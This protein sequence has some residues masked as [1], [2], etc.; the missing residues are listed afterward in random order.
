MRQV[1]TLN[2]P[3]QYVASACTLYA[4]IM[5][6]HMPE[7]GGSFTF[8]YFD[9][10]IVNS[11]SS[12]PHD[13]TDKSR[14]ACDSLSVP[15][16][17]DMS[18]FVC[19]LVRACVCVYMCWNRKGSSWQTADANITRVRKQAHVVVEGGGWTKRVEDRRESGWSR[20]EGSKSVRKRLI[21]G[22]LK[23]RKSW[24]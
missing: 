8:S 1:K 24:K 3:Q 7:P 23:L 6:Q 22:L 17:K 2:W 11:I 15:Y 20:G 18:E 12:C 16:L 10:A 4:P 9:I 5:W 13:S 19:V 14:Q 21:P